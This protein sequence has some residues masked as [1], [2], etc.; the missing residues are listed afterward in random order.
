MASAKY[1]SVSAPKR[2]SAQKWQI[3]IKYSKDAPFQVKYITDRTLLNVM[4]KAVE[5]LE[6]M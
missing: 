1:I 3:S 4:R 5:F 6:G 2:L